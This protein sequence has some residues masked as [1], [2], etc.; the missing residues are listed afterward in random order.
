MIPAR[1]K[2]RNQSPQN[3]Q[4]LIAICG[5]VAAF[6][7]FCPQSHASC[8][9]Y[10]ESTDSLASHA[11]ASQFHPHP[12]APKPCSGPSCSAKIPS[13]RENAAPISAPT[14]QRNNDSVLFLIE[15]AIEIGAMA[16]FEF[17]QNVTVSSFPTDFVFRPPR[18]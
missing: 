5:F 14:V 15:P 10:V 3:W 18:A 16:S 17:F 11:R 13:R 7:A 12:S 2:C 8:G 9:D 1:N 4:R 6:L